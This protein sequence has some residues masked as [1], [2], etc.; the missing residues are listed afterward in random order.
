MTLPDLF[1]YLGA[2]LANPRWSWGAVR[3]ADGAVFL[4]VWQD[5]QRKIAGAGFSQVTFDHF[6]NDNPSNLGYIERLKHVERVRNGASS[7]LLM[8]LARDV[9][10]SPREVASF[11]RNDIFVGGRL[12]EAEGNYWLERCARRPLSAAGLA[13]SQPQSSQ[14]MRSG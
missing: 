5:E 4:R 10:A 11:D 3:P 2:P 9:H 13:P 6:F 8:C 7:Y 1:A 12:V 14:Q